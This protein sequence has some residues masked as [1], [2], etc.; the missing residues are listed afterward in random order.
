MIKYTKQQ[1]VDI[2]TLRGHHVVEASIRTTKQPDLLICANCG[3]SAAFVEGS[4]HVQNNSYHKVWVGN[5]C[6]TYCEGK[7]VGYNPRVRN[8][9][10]FI[11]EQEQ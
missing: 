6:V 9:R 1:I 3:E 5:L 11:R 10:D 4:I 2:C 7:P 8:V